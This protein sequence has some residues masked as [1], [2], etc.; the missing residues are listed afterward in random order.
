MSQRAEGRTGYAWRGLA[1]VMAVASA[2]CSRIKDEPPKAADANTPAAVHSQT[3]CN[4]PGDRKEIAGLGAIVDVP[5]YNDCQKLATGDPA[6][7]GPKVG[8]YVSAGLDTLFRTDMSRSASG[9]PTS[10]N[11]F[12]ALIHNFGKDYVTQSLTIKSGYSCLRL[13]P[14]PGV[15]QATIEDVGAAVPNCL[16]PPTVTPRGISMV[17]AL[18]V[19]PA[20]FEDYPPVARWEW[21]PA[22]LHHYVGIKCGPAWCEVGGRGEP[23]VGVGEAPPNEAIPGLPSSP[24]MAGRTHLVKGWYDEQA[25]AIPGTS[26]PLEPRVRARIYPHQQLEAVTFDLFGKGWVPA[27]YVYLPEA[28]APYHDALHLSQGLNTIY[29]CQARSTLQDHCAGAAAGTF[30]KCAPSDA[31]TNGEPAT[32]WYARIMPTG[33]TDANAA[34]YI[35]VTKQQHV[36]VDIRATTRW[37]WAD[38]DEKI[39]IRCT[40]GCCTVV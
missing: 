23:D 6:E 40:N 3:D 25:L 11:V 5:E 21:D 28:S 1:V 16:K 37:R 26:K 4:L 13:R 36:G 19:G 12:V 33:T 2:A 8:I 9:S 14:G 39:W 17:R 35:C 18:H 7:Y 29:L 34:G 20:H 22:Q 31:D 15:Y 38:D 27:A 24:G 32:I 10:G 30:G